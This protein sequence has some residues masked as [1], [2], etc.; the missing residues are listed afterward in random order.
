MIT[1]EAAECS[2]NNAPPAEGPPNDDDDNDDA[3]DD[4]D[5][6]RPPGFSGPRKSIVYPRSKATL[7]EKDNSDEPPAS[8]QKK[9]KTEDPIP[10]AGDIPL[11]YCDWKQV[12]A[13]ED[14][15]ERITKRKLS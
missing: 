7:G 4:D 12:K 9:R 14:Y 2:T 5:E 15:Q 8:A 1:H 11:V 3:A 10:P 13:S 6:D